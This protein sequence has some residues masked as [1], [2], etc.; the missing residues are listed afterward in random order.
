MA[1][2]HCGWSSER[3]R[4]LFNLSINVS[5]RVRGEP[6]GPD[7]TVET[8]H[9]VDTAV[10]TKRICLSIVNSI[11]DPMGLL[12]PITI[13]LKVMMKQMFSAEYDLKWD[14]A[15]PKELQLQWVL[16]LSDLVGIKLEFDRSIMHIEAYGS[17]VLAAFWDGSDQAF[18]AV[19]YAIWLV[20]DNPVE[21]RLV[22]SK[23]RVSSEWGKN[24]VRQELNGSVLCTRLLVKTVR[25]ME[26][27]P[28]RVWVAGDSETVLASREKHSGYFSEFYS[29]R[30][31]ET[32]DNQK[33]V[34]VICP[35]GEAGEW[36]HISG[37]ENP[38]DRP[39][40]V[41]SKPEDIK[42]GSEWQVGKQFLR[43]PRSLWPLERKFASERKDM[44]QIPLME[45]NRKYRN[46]AKL[47]VPSNT[48]NLTH[49]ESTV[50]IMTSSDLSPSI[51]Q[52]GPNGDAGWEEGGRRVEG[53]PEHYGHRVLVKEEVMG[54]EHMNNPIVKKFQ[55]GHITNDWQKLLRRTAIYFKWVV[56]VAQKRVGVDCLS[57]HH[58]AILFWIKQAMPETRKAYREKKLQ[59]LT[60]WEHDGLLVVSGRAMEG[61]K[62]YFGV[63]YLPVLMSNTRVAELI[64]LDSHTM[65]HGGRDT[66]LVTATQTAWIVGAGGWQER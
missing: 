18:A 11:Y 53:V 22:A 12:T 40:R 4:F 60:L 2:F 49:L 34:E 58:M 57:A 16:M 17:P 20:K 5:S 29:N 13:N 26:I 39:S 31:G 66:T 23:A 51:S 54:P 62:H 27:K 50:P 42:Y 14:Q 9:M 3:D 33:K 44:I 41:G 30:I 28:E 65:D 63:S 1:G 59:K 7:L 32:H 21:V 46:L 47:D 24:T 45:I 48:V 19:I 55:G 35:V 15:L 10:L 61:L 37:A 43:M 36:W 64:M 38:A 52:S 8:I 25:A 56:T 6:T